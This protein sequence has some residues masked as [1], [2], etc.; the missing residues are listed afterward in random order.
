MIL[1]P[2]TD[3]EVAIGVAER[4]CLE[5]N[6][7]EF[8]HGPVSVSVGISQWTPEHATVDD[9]LKAVDIAMYES[10]Q[11]GGMKVSVPDQKA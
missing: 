2:E 11:S 5:V 3:L 1:L 10:K 6:Q 8:Q 9:L 4:I 7:R